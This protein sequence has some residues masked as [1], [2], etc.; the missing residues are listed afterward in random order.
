MRLSDYASQFCGRYW[1][2]HGFELPLLVDVQPAGRFLCE[3]FHR[4]GGV[5]AV[6]GELLAAGLLDGTCADMR[7]D[8]PPGLDPDKLPGTP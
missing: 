5:P 3:S 6:M 2:E 1:G 7:G 4:A 8:T